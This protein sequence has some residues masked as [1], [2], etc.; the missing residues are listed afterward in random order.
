[1]KEASVEVFGNVESM[2]GRLAEFLKEITES[3]G[4]G[5]NLVLSGGNTPRLILN[6][7]ARQHTN[8]SWKKV[9]F[10]WGDERMVPPDHP[11]SNYRMAKESLLSWIRPA[12]EQIH[13][14]RGEYD[15]ETE[16]ERYSTEIR[17]H[18]KTENGFPVFD[19]ILLGLGDDGHTASIFP[20]Q[21]YL[22]QDDEICRRAVHPDTGQIRISLT[23]PVINNARAIIFLVTGRK[24]S[25][26]VSEILQGKDKARYYPAFHI[27]PGNGKMYWL[28][29]HEA[30]L[31][32]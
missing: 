2:A 7:L 22:L 16:A 4:Q 31:D 17:N 12:D 18:L 24:K 29:D 32:L 28:L 8:L 10:Y 30:S 23:G 5:I 27:K 14:I 20:D 6:H 13:R 15:P 11:E 9:Q 21:M 25:K 3:S 26:I 1:M 19:L